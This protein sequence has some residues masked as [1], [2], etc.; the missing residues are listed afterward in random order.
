MYFS[1]PK[2]G[3]GGHAEYRNGQYQGPKPPPDFELQAASAESETWCCKNCSLL[4]IPAPP[5]R[6]RRRWNTHRDQ[7]CL[8]E[9][10]GSRDSKYAAAAVANVASAATS[11]AA[12]ATTISSTYLYASGARAYINAIAD[13]GAVRLSEHYENSAAA[14]PAASSASST[15]ATAAAAAAS[16]TA[17]AAVTVE[18]ASDGDDDM[19]L[20]IEQSRET[21]AIE[22]EQRLHRRSSVGS[23]SADAG[24]APVAAIP[25]AGI[26]T[27][28]PTSTDNASIAS[29]CAAASS[30]IASAAAIGATTTVCIKVP[31]TLVHDREQRAAYEACETREEWLRRM[32]GANGIYVSRPFTEGN[33]HASP[34]VKAGSMFANPYPVGDGEGK[35]SDDESM[36]R[37]LEYTQVRASPSATTAQVIK[38]LP[39]ATQKLAQKRHAG[40]VVREEQGLSV[41]HLRLDIVGP[42]FWGELRKLRGRTLGCW[43]SPADQCHARILVR[44]AETLP[45]WPNEAWTITWGDVAMNEVQMQRIGQEA[46]HGVSVAQL[47]EIQKQLEVK[48]MS[49]VLIDLRQ[50]LSDAQRSSAPEAAVLVVRNGVN[51]LSEDAQGEAK[52][53]AEQRSMPIDMQAFDRKHGGV[54]NKYNRY[55]NLLG[56]YNLLADYANRKGT[57]V[58]CSKYPIT[59][60]LRTTFTSLLGA[61]NMLVGE[62]N[63]YYEAGECGIGWHG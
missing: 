52:L 47:H 9:D 30:A 12:D 15:A 23:S 41:A 14:N 11:N 51:A 45:Q 33:W 4:V 40:G 42:A 6:R 13:G 35:F 32:I 28:V 24:V 39:L 50:L 31:T 38:L 63:H 36:R 60:K 5:D 25:A 58:D 2:E 7:Q 20:A 55:N 1:R 26:P 17:A 43:C 53:L 49:C 21:A 19:H 27:A 48:G 54:F 3:G 44:L 59:T 18:G 62:T 57:V 61:S 46:A 37:F 34:T 10:S 22:R 56:D 16:T 29:T 8:H